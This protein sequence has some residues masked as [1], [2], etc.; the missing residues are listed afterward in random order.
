MVIASHCN[1]DEIITLVK[2]FKTF[3]KDK[4]GTITIN[5]L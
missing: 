5:E 3:D 2:K 4:N 1:E